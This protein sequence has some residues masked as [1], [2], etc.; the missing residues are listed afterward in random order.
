MTT[1]AERLKIARKRAGLTQ[2]VIADTV[3]IKQPTYQALES[4]K[5]EKSAYLLQ[6]AN[7]L[8]VDSNWLATGQGT[9]TNDEATWDNNVQPVPPK[10]LLKQAPVLNCI[11]AGKF[12]NMGDNSY[13]EYLPYFGDY[14]KDNVYWLKIQGNSMMTDFKEGEYVLINKDRQPTAGNYVAA[15]QEGKEQATF[16]KYRPKGFDEN[17]VEY[18]HL[19][20]SNPEFPIIDSRY[21]PFE[22]LG[23]AVER[24][25]KLV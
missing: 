14:G 6:I 13:D 20:P 12:T 17:G 19:V 18:W 2:A 4:G 8:K 16:K 5:V 9:M 21:Q 25:Q 7:I 11:Q 22:V 10:H 15:L 23:V 24:N 1:L 3:G